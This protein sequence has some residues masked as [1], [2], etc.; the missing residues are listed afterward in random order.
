MAMKILHVCEYVRGG[1]TTY[2]NEILKYQAT[3]EQVSSVHVLMSEY[4]SDKLLI[5]GVQFDYYHYKRKLSK[6]IPAI[7]QINRVIKKIHPDVIHI[8]SSFAGLFVRVCFF[9]KR[10]RPKI[11]YCA[12]GW[13][14]LMEISHV[15][16]KMYGILERVL[17]RKTDRIINISD[18]EFIGSLKY[19][20]PKEK[21]LVIPNGIEDRL[22][23]NKDVALALDPSKLN[24]LFVGRFDRQKGID[25]LLDFFK[26][27]PLKHVR[28]Y[29]IG[30]NVL[31]PVLKKIPD[32]I[33]SLGWIDHN[34]IDSY[35]EKFDAVIIPSRWEGFGLV[36]IEAMKNR[37]AVIASNRGDLPDLVKDGVN[38]YLFDLNHLEELTRIL[39]TVSKQELEVMG[40]RGFAI[41]QEKYTGEKLNQRLMDVYQQLVEGHGQPTVHRTGAQYEAK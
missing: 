18:H 21:S 28:L 41:F 17:A 29:T 26:N 14:F 11:V 20:L 30:G 13:S 31:D 8:H 32:T 10:K 12:H 24:L 34:V 1:I 22:Y 23:K 33:I 27:D 7:I 6:F 36:A 37:K 5:N 40:E 9:F 35:Y 15:K 2:L 4:N 16:K 19:K 25:I 39:T 38:G 3:T